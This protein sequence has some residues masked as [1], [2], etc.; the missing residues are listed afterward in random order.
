MILF[1]RYVNNVLP[2]QALYV[3]QASTKQEMTFAVLFTPLE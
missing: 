1:R 2:S 3:L